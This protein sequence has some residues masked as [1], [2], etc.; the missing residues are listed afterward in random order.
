[1]E[2]VLHCL[3]KV[4]VLEGMLHLENAKIS[5]T[6]QKMKEKN[7]DIHYVENC[8][9]LIY[10]YVSSLNKRDEIQDELLYE[11]CTDNRRRNVSER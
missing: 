1:M 3:A 4:K 9:E 8:D 6:L 2:S 5:S 11:S 7:C 10:D